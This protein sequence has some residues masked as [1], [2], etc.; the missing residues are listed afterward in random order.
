MY[1]YDPESGAFREDTSDGRNAC[2]AIKEW[3]RQGEMD[4][5]HGFQH[6]TRDQVLPLLE[7]FY[8]WC[9]EA[10]LPKPSTWINHSVR[11]CPSGLCPEAFRPNR[12]VTLARQI[13]R[14]AIGPMLGVNR[15]PISWRQL[16]YQ[17]ARPGS[18]YYINDILHANGLKYVWLE[19]DHDELANVIALPERSYAGRSSFL[20]QVTMDDGIRYHRF[21]R[22]YGKVHARRGVVVALRT[23][24]AAFDASM[25]FTDENLEQLCRV[26]GTCILYTH[27]TVARSLPVQDATIGNFHRLRRYRDQGKIWVPRLSRLLEWTRLRTFLRYSTRRDGAALLIDIES[28]DD[29]LFG[30]QQLTLGDCDGLAFDLPAGHGGPVGIRVD[31]KDVPAGSIARKASVCWIRRAG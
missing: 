19:A 11:A 12:A 17:G 14:N 21:R 28:L 23:S 9:E 5:F 31:G 7:R 13:A 8:R 10:G 20:E 15:L 29:P 25:L 3:I 1:R 4:S 2:E 24:P 18:P 6:F 30:R 16:W 22:C 27:W 26:G